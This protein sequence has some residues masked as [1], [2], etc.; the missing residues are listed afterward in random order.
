MIWVDN[1]AETET[2]RRDVW[3]LS[4]CHVECECGAMFRNLLLHRPWLPAF[5]LIYQIRSRIQRVC[6]GSIDMVI[7]MPAS[8]GIDDTDLA[9][10][11][12]NARQLNTMLREQVHQ[13]VLDIAPVV[14]MGDAGNADRQ[15]LLSTLTKLAH[16]Q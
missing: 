4:Q 2:P 12:A 8:V 3:R 16:P 13:T 11:V 9:N 6:C 5:D 1:H 10:Q 15:L 14:A 7:S